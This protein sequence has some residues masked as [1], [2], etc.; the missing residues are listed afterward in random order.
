M[1][2]LK[3]SSFVELLFS[4]C[5]VTVKELLMSCIVKVMSSDL[6]LLSSYLSSTVHIVIIKGCLWIVFNLYQ[7]Y[8]LCLR[9][10]DLCK[11]ARGS[12]F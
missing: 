4:S 11:G 7:P 5:A 3:S 8:F 12:R 6:D 2:G 9:K 1:N 10:H